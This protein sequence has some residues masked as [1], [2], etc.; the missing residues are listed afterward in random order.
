MI[1]LYDLSQVYIVCNK[2]DLRKGIYGLAILI[3]EQ[4]EILSLLVAKFTSS[5]VAEKTA[6]RSFIG[7][8]KALYSEQVD[9]LMEGFAISPKIKNTKVREFP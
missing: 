1:K 5:G 4:F 7:T 9:W 2:T 3:K 6:S 8:V